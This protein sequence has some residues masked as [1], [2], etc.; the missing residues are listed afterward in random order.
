MKI[1][2]AL[3]VLLFPLSLLAGSSFSAAAAFPSA[4]LA[5]VGDAHIVHQI[6]VNKP[7][8]CVLAK[9]FEADKFC[10]KREGDMDVSG[11]AF[12]VK[13]GV[14]AQFGMK[15]DNGA[16]FNMEY[17][18]TCVVD[19]GAPM[20]SPKVIVTIGAKG[21]ADPDVSAVELYGAKATWQFQGSSEAYQLEF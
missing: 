16:D 14:P 15:F 7:A 12:S 5:C 13:P 10:L 17:A 20:K 18:F 4:P 3:L 8:T 6:S 11:Q 19:D 9:L 1:T 2:R 21:P